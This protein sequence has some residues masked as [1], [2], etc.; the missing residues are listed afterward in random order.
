MI[1]LIHNTRRGVNCDMTKQTV[2]INGREYDKHT[3]MP[4]GA[5]RPSSAPTQHAHAVHHHTKRS[6]TLDRRYV[7]RAHKTTETTATPAKETT[8]PPSKHTISK[9][10]KHPQTSS[11]KSSTIS[12][13]GPRPHPMHQAVKTAQASHQPQRAKTIAKPSDIIKAEAIEKALATA[14]TTHQ[15]HRAKAPKQTKQHSRTNRML[16]LASA[17]TALL[18]LGG[19]FTYLNMPNL[20]VRVAA[21]QAGIDASYPSYRP[22][23]YSISGPVAYK[24]GQ[25]QMKFAARGGPQ[26]FTLVQE[27]SGWDSEAVLENYVTPK[28][29]Q[30]YSIT[31]DSGLTVYTWGE[32]AAWISG[33]ILYTV[34]GDA[35]LAP[36]QIRRMATSL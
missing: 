14:P 16:S 7:K 24:S 34:N 28:A 21:A 19:Y 32:N 36:D 12:D 6:E 22:S 23:G 8:L 25:V 20:S 13:I 17:G 10:A 30:D 11:K 29:G 4:I 9:Y 2:T 31:R 1:V 15:R 5:Q 35:P 33:G 3:G 18:L 26:S 27:R